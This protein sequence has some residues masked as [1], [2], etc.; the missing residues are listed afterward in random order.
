MRVPTHPTDVRRMLFSRLKRVVALSQ[1]GGKNIVAELAARPKTL[2]R[3][4]PADA[5]WRQ[6]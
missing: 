5:Q 1:S 4:A 2:K 6:L 3:E